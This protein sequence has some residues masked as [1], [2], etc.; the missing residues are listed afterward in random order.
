MGIRRGRARDE[1]GVGE[2]TY[3][4]T[5]ET[6]SVG[7][8]GVSP[9]WRWGGIGDI[10]P[11]ES[12]ADGPLCWAFVRLH[13]RYYTAYHN[14]ILEYFDTLLSMDSWVPYLS[15]SDSSL[16]SSLEVYHRLEAI[17]AFVLDI[18]G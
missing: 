18:T 14:S 3:A 10:C 6:A 13:G 4:V 7:R 11:E 1:T 8:N 17:Y 5:H 9:R 2:V 15:I 16:Y 12:K